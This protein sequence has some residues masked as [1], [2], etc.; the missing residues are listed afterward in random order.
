MIGPSQPYRGRYAAEFSAADMYP[1]TFILID[2]VLSD[3]SDSRPLQPVNGTQLSSLLRPGQ[4]LI[5]GYKQKWVISDHDVERCAGVRNDS[6]LWYGRKHDLTELDRC[7][8][9]EPIGAWEWGRWE[10]TVGVSGRVWAPVR[11]HTS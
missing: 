2:D 1:P 8:A 7:V 3:L 5:D 10:W 11:F 6:I 9:R 4:I